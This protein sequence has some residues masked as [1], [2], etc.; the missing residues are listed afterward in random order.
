MTMIHFETDDAFWNAF[1]QFNVLCGGSFFGWTPTTARKEHEDLFSVRIGPRETYFRKDIGSFRDA[2]KLSMASME[3]ILY[4]IIGLN[5][6]LGVGLQMK[7]DK[8]AE[9]LVSRLG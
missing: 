2:E 9:D 6:N 8:A 5:P 4:V 1:E 3:R 7:L